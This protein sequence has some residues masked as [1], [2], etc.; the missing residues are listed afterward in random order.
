MC[1]VERAMLK[2]AIWLLLGA[3]ALT[4]SRVP[5]APGSTPPNTPNPANNTASGGTGNDRPLELK[6]IDQVLQ[7]NPRLTANLKTLLSSDVTPQQAC[8]G[9]KTLEQCIVAIHTAQNLKLNF[10][11][12]KEKTTGKHSISLQKAIEQMAAQADAKEE[13]KKAKKQASEDMKGVS[14]FGSYLPQRWNESGV[15][16]TS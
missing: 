1:S 12:L 3:T 16:S 11:D 13:V 10:S 4:Q 2:A 5:S 14:L 7:D 9:F 15:P 8:S 6:S